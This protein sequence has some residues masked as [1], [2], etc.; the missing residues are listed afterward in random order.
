M[1]Y[2][3]HG[4]PVFVHTDYVVAVVGHTVDEV[5]LGGIAA[6]VDYMGSPEAD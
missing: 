3:N 4:A 1:D 6:G 5:C 2:G